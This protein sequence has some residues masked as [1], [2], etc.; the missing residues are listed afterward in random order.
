MPPPCNRCSIP[1]SAPLAVDANGQYRAGAKP[2]LRHLYRLGACPPRLCPVAWPMP[3]PKAQSST[4]RGC[5][6]PGW[7]PARSASTAWCP[8]PSPRDQRGS[9]RMNS[10]ESDAFFQKLAPLRTRAGASVSLTTSQSQH[11]VFAAGRLDHGR[12]A[13]C[14]W[15]HGPGRHQ[16][17]TSPSST[18]PSTYE[19]DNSMNRAITL[20][21]ATVKGQLLALP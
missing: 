4:P 12:G 3:P 1:T 2:R 8:A 6:P 7:A 15:Q 5:W 18:N 11:R 21:E 13:R 14:R 16:A 9:Q 10:R 19:G 20:D 17:M